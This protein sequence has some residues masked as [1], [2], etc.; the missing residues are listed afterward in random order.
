MTNAMKMRYFCC[1]LLC[2]LLLALPAGAQ[3][4]VYTEAA[5]LTLVG[6]LFP[7]T[8]NPY[9]RVDTVKYKGFTKAENLQVRESS[10]IA[11]AFRTNSPSL[12]IHT[13]FGEMQNYSNT[14]G[15]S[16]SGYDLYI[17]KDGE[18]LWAGSGPRNAKFEDVA[19]ASGLDGWHDCLLY[20]PLFS[21]EYSVQIGVET[22]SALEALENPFRHRS[23]VY[24]SSFTH[25]AS[26][27]RPGMTY[28][29]QLA[30]WTGL[31][32]LSLGCSGNCKMQPYY[33]DALMD[34]DVDAFLFDTFSNPTEKQIQ[35]RLFPFIEKMVASHPGKPLIFQRTIYRENRNFDTASEKKEASR[36]VLVDSLMAIACARY[37]DVY[38][39]TPNATS[40][41]HETS[42]DGIHPGDYGYTRW[43]ASIEQQVLEILKKYGIE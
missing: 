20:L 1:A 33:A 14:G 6:K 17:R 41:L 15:I 30:R 29:A 24:G 18:W 23:G 37:P 3:E 19:L 34:A 16:L 32:L 36:A 28:P 35:E 10:G 27:S 2:A 40:E 12:R 25:G 4:Y 8:P 9:H 43:A 21:E 31:Q 13:R 38:L 26:T 42:V 5:E 22:G 39:I 11:V 7:D